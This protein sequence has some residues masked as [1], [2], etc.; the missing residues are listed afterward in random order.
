[1]HLAVV[2]SDA[3]FRSWNDPVFYTQRPWTFPKNTHVEVM[4]PAYRSSES[5]FCTKG[6]P[7]WQLML[8]GGESILL[9]YIYT[10]IYI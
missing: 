9:H 10:H 5:S 4:I 7:T 6:G 1:M 2:I 8:L 3:K